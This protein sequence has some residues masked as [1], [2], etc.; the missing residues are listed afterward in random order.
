[1]KRWLIV[2]VFFL[3]TACSTP[4]PP[5]SIPNSVPTNAI[6]TVVPIPTLLPTVTTD[7]QVTTPSASP[8]PAGA[9]VTLAATGIPKTA[10]KYPAP[11]QVAPQPPARFSDGNDIKFVYGAVGALKANECYLLHI[12]LVNPAVN[13]GNRGDDFLDK[14]HCGDQGPAGKK[15]EY[16]LF[17]SK[18][19]TSPN[20]GTI[21]QQA[22]ALAPNVREMKMTWVLRV[23]QNNGPAA[24]GVHF[25]TVALSP[26]SPRV[27]FDFQP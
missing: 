17:R 8:L 26:F 12:E 6:A 16:V 4:P 23:V 9:T 27:E 14:P 5:T 2:A 11:V 18:F 21:L 10:F 19:T 24:D 7:Q 13:P 15:L 22:S 25:N 1:M 20:Y 3:V